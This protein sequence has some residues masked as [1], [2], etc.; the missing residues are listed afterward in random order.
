MQLPILSEK[1]YPK[2]PRAS[3]HLYRNKKFVNKLITEILQLIGGALWHHNLAD[4]KELAS[5]P[6]SPNHVCAVW[7]RAHFDHFKWAVE[8]VSELYKIYDRYIRAT[9]EGHATSR[10]KI[11]FARA[12]VRSVQLGHLK[13]PQNLKV[14]ELRAELERIRLRRPKS[15]QEVGPPLVSTIGIPPDLSCVALAIDAEWRESLGISKKGHDVHAVRT[16]R[17]YHKEKHDLDDAP[18]HPERRSAQP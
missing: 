4:D 10:V 6:H 12:V 5:K 18:W 14:D 16:Y 2:G 7:V 8:H 17:Q 3:A 15:K 1:G 9:P 13:W 11:I